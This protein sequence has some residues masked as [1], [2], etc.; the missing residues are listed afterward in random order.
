VVSLVQECWAVVPLLKLDL[1]FTSAGVEC[2]PPLAEFSKVLL[3]EFD[4]MAASLGELQDHLVGAIDCRASSPSLS[5]SAWASDPAFVD[6]RCVISTQVRP[7][8]LIGSLCLN[9]MGYG[10]AACDEIILGQS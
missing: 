5:A 8:R 2:N 10:L 6:A 4:G 9:K 1:Q 3:E 7:Q